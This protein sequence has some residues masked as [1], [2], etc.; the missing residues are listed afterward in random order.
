MME[1]L[2]SMYVSLW[3][4]VSKRELNLYLLLWEFNR[5]YL[6]QEDQAIA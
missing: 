1:E 2:G 5:Y 6:N 3:C 4:L